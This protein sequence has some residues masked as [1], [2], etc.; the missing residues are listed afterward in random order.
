M[1]S[2]ELGVGFAV[3]FIRRP[4]CRATDL[5]S[6]IGSVRSGL[7][8]GAR[9]EPRAL[10]LGSA[11][12]APFDV[13]QGRQGLRV[14][15]RERAAFTLIELLAC[16]PKPWRRKVRSA[17]TLIE[18]L[19]VISI[20][21]LLIT[22]LLPALGRARS[23]AL[24]AA[25]GSNQ[26]QILTALMAYGADEDG[27]LPPGSGYSPFASVPNRGLEGSGD[28]WDELFPAYLPEVDV[29]YCP[30]GGFFADTPWVGGRGPMWDFQDPTNHGSTRNANFSYAVLCNAYEVKGA[31]ENIPT[32][33]SDSPDWVLTL[34]FT[35]IL[36]PEH[37][38][39]L[40]NHPG[41]TPAWAPGWSGPEGAPAEGV[42]KGTL[43]GSV[44]WVPV[45]QTVPGYPGGGGIPES[46]RWRLIE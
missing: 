1:T 5:A 34:D 14:H 32:R 6:G 42:N 19:V 41:A 29:W 17:F 4:P 11:R 16:H 23:A 15:E 40:T 30:D 18:L 31:Y 36:W 27:L 24:V 12:I 3:M 44:S 21:A 13:A 7:T 26:R 9:A 25:C 39:V 45:Q 2:V 22:L 43:G 20:V 35:I 8:F 33:L 46:L 37:Y 10:C 38:W 28:F